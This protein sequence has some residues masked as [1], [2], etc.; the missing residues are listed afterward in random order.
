MFDG[1][2][3]LAILAIDKWGVSDDLG[4]AH[5]GDVFGAY[6]AIL[7]CVSHLFPAK[8]EKLCLRIASA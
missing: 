1:A 8:A 7:P 4:D 3:E 2:D 6:D 5:V